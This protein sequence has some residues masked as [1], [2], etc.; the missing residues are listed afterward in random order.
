MLSNPQRLTKTTDET[1]QSLLTPPGLVVALRHNLHHEGVQ[2]RY[3]A[4][5]SASEKAPVERIYGG[6]SGAPPQLGYEW[7]AV[8]PTASRRG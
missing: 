6:D 2:G 1:D 7:W 4:M 3:K 8:K 5:F